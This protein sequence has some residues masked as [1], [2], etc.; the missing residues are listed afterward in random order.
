MA[1]FDACFYINDLYYR[2][3]CLCVGVVAGD[4]GAWVVAVA[5]A[6]LLSAIWDRSVALHRIRLGGYSCY[7]RSSAFMLLLLGKAVVV[8]KDQRMTRG[9]QRER[10]SG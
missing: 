4:G 5:V 10:T 9:G 8:T 2:G 1:I 7:D 3:M 6:V